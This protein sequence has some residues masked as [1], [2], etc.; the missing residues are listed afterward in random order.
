MRR[1]DVFYCAMLLQYCHSARGTEELY[2]QNTR[3]TD[4]FV[5]RDALIQYFHNMKASSDSI[6]ILLQKGKK[7]PLVNKTIAECTLSLADVLQ[8]PLE[9]G[10]TLILHSTGTTRSITPQ[11]RYY[12]P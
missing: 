6:R 7:R 1:T 8:N 2:C 9:D 11:Y 12:S 10:S 3:G 4:A 5:L